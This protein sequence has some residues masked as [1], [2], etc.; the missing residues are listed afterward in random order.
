MG[1]LLP[2]TLHQTFLLSRHVQSYPI[3]RTPRSCL[4][5]R[6]IGLLLAVKSW[7]GHGE[8]RAAVRE[9]WGREQAGRGGGAAWDFRESFFNVT[10]KELLFWRWFRQDCPAALYVLKADDDVFVDVPRVL[11]LLRRQPGPA[12]PLYLGRA[13][14]GTY[15][16]RQL[17]SKYY[18]PASLYPSVPYPPYLG[19]GGYLVSRET[20]RLFLGA[21][22]AVPLFP[23]DDAYVGMCAQVANVSA[24]HH[25][26]FLPF[27]FSPSLPP[28]SYTGALVLHRLE[29][30]DL[31]LLWGFYRSQGHACPTQEALSLNEE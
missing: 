3:L 17:W 4:S 1:Q 6:P 23:I 5:Q 31:H 20:I 28:C 22:A 8:R 21:S 30:R 13:F 11:A 14:V 25:R 9:T 10:L 29:P 19:G 24:T 12:R 2:T 18:V 15:P 16:V 7:A 27:E 26:G